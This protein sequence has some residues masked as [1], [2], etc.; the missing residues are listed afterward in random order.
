M[1]PSPRVPFGYGLTYTTFEYSSPEASTA[2]IA[3]ESE[4]EVAATIT[5]TGE[6]PGVEVVQLYLRDRTA[7]IVRPVRELI[8]F[9]RAGRRCLPEIE[10]PD[11]VA[12]A[13]HRESTAPEVPGRRV[14]H[15]QSQRGG[16]GRVD[17][18][19]SRP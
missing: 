8:G 12:E 11:F 7:R 18:I 4:F 9:R 16:H 5:N 10:G 1:T 15:S 13:N 6:R 14:D 19:T 3:R 17:G 2:E